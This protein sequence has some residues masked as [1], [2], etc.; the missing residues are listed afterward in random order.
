VRCVGG[1]RA[2]QIWNELHG[3][4]YVICI[5]HLGQQP[6]ICYQQQMMPNRPD[7]TYNKSRPLLT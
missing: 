5:C 1:L 2:I 6:I 3:M 4:R 7:I